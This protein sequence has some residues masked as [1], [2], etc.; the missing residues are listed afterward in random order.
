MNFVPLII[1]SIADTAIATKKR[2]TS[3][4]STIPNKSPWI[5]IISIKPFFAIATTL[6]YSVNQVLQ[7]VRYLFRY[8]HDFLSFFKDSII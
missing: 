2:L 5:S 7:F 4:T 6:Q 8:S 1:N 3:H